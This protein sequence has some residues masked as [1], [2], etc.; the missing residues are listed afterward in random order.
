NNEKDFEKETHSSTDVSNKKKPDCI[1]F[2]QPERTDYKILHEARV[3]HDYEAENEDELNLVKDEYIS[4]ISFYNEENNIRDNGW[5]YAEKS[6]GT[7]GLFP[8]NFAVR[9]YDNEKKQ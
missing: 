7:I 2:S 8:V 1:P 6:D 5:E 4:V 9:L 3:I